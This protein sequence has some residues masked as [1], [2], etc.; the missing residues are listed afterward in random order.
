MTSEQ[1]VPEWRER[2]AQLGLTADV[3]R[4]LSR[5]E[6]SISLDAGLV[7]RLAELLASPAG[8]TQ[9]R[10]TF[11]RR[12]VVQA[13]CERLPAAAEVRVS[14]VE[15]LADAFLHSP[16][17]VV[18]AEGE[19]C[20]LLR[21][22]D[23]HAIPGAAVERSYS[24][25]ELLTLERRILDYATGGRG[26]RR[27]VARP[28]VT[29]RAIARRASLSGEQAEMVRR[30]TTDGD[31]VAVVVGQA[32]AGKTFALG[33][34]R[35]AWEASGR[36]VYG[37]ALARRAA[38]ELEDGAGIPP[39]SIAALLAALDRRPSSTLPLRSVLV[40]D[41]AGMLPTRQLAQ[42]VEHAQRRRVKLVLVGDHRQLPS[43][44]AG[45]AF[46]ASQARLPAIVLK[47]NRRQAAAWERDALA[48][49]ATATRKK[50]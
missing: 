4:A 8:L 22:R 27:A 29:E 13:F 20:E 1:L 14:D 2:A 38:R 43:I 5:Q 49:F 39:T 25:P 6:Q 36:R 41:E 33:V 21:R 10:S 40:L 44:G 30:L 47:E 35:E 28:Q 9:L 11:T 3:V 19:R 45:G 18:L 7:E 50:R 37:A 12:D 31:A 34:A 17:A 26:A 32:G 24:T 23:G 42:L 15:R 46:Q 16:H 48:S